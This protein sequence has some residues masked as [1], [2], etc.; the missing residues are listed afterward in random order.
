MAV[1]L[2]ILDWICHF[3]ATNKNN[4]NGAIL[5]WFTLLLSICSSI[6][7]LNKA[8]NAGFLWSCSYLGTVCRNDFTKYR[9]TFLL[10]FIA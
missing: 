9:L 3:M 8:W 5:L 1:Q 7:I 10:A 6:H 4:L 2:Y